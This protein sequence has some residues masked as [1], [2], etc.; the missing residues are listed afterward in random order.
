MINAGETARLA[1]MTAH[2]V[3]AKPPAGDPARGIKPPDVTHLGYV[4][5]A[6]PVRVYISGDPIHTFADLDE[7]VDLRNCAQTGRGPADHASVR[8]RVPLLR[9]LGTN[10]AARRPQ[11]RRPRALRLL[12]QA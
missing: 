9:R 1:T 5:E 4:V 10:G 7:L 12:R 3:Y 6:D 11:G 2:A 8:G